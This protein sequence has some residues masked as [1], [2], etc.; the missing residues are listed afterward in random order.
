MSERGGHRGRTVDSE[1]TGG[2]G[3]GDAPSY[4]LC[5]LGAQVYGIDFRLPMMPTAATSPQD[6]VTP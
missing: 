6:A 5:Y 1:P 3:V 4:G 2:L